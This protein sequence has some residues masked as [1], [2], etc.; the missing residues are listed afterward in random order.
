MH[1][2]TLIVVIRLYKLS[3]AVVRRCSVK[4]VLLKIWQNSQESTCA[5]VSFLKRRLWHGCFPANFAKLLR[6]LFFCRTVLVAAYK[7]FYQGMK[8]SILI[9]LICYAWFD[10]IWFDLVIPSNYGSCYIMIWY[11]KIKAKI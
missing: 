9:F 1:C 10:L 6:T 4:K 11:L 3:K 7:L 5:R 8:L 2:P